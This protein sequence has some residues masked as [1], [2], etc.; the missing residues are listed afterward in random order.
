MGSRPA[1]SRPRPVIFEAKAMARPKSLVLE[2]KGRHV[3][4]EAKA[5]PVVF[6]AKAMI[7]CP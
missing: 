7:F 3:S 6:K 1:F 2:T 5:R 4:F